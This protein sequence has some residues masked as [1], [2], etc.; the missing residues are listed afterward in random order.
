MSA[1]LA[2]GHG[3]NDAQKSVG[4]IAALL[5]A[6]GRLASLSAP[7]W[8]PVACA[9]ALT[10]GTALGGWSIVKTVGRR[11]YRIT[12]LDGVASQTASAG[13]IF[14]AS[15]V[16]APV[17]TTQVVASSVLGV[18]GVRRRWRHLNWLLVRHVARSWPV[19][20]PVT[21]TSTPAALGAW[22]AL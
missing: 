4:V 5:V 22:S 15:L 3:A 13:V 20:L 1:S 12:P 2:F 6:D 14:G 9:L 16:G 7:I 17:S 8:A 19:T 18:G 11:I 10:A 21:A